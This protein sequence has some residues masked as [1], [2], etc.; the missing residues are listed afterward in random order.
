MLSVILY[1]RNDSYGYN[2][3]K[4]A[5][6]SLNCIAEMLSGEHDEI[7]FVDYNTP[8]DVPTFIE[9]IYDTL[10]PR[11][12]R[13]LR[14]LRVRPDIHNR[15]Y[16]TRTH[17]A[18]LEPICRNIGARRSN[19]QNRWILSTN[20]DM[21]FVPRN[22]EYDL[23]IAVSDLADG[24]Y[25]VPR[26][27]LPEPFW[28][29][30]PRTDPVAIIRTCD[31]LGA[32]LHL[33]E[34]TLAHPYMRFDN[35]GDAQ[36]LP[37][38]TLFDIF[39]F[40][41]R[42][43]HGW[44]VDSNM[45]KRLFHLY[46]AT[47]SLADRLKGYHCDHT[48][49][50]TLAHR[51][52]FQIESDPREFVYNIENPYAQHQSHSWGLP[53]DAIEEIDFG[54]GPP[55]R[56]VSVIQRT[57]GVPQDHDYHSD[58]NDG[59]NYLFY[60]PEHVLPY[61]AAN[62]TV[63]PRDVRLL[64]IGNNP[65]LLTLLATCFRDL[66]F[67][68]PLGWVPDLMCS[69]PPKLADGVAAA[70]EC[71]PDDPSFS[72]TLITNHDV[73][74]FDFGLDAA[75]LPSSD[76][77]RIT[78]WP[79]DQR[80][81]LGAI[82][83]CLA[84]C[85]EECHP[86]SRSRPAASLPDFLVVN[87]N[88][89]P[90]DQFVSQFLLTTKTPYNTR[91][92]KGRARVGDERLYRSH[93]W[94]LTEE[95]MQSFFGY[96]VQ[97]GSAP[98]IA[99]GDCIDFTSLAS[100]SPYKDGDWGVADHTGTW[101]DGRRA[102]VLLSI[103]PAV[104]AD[105]IA[106]VYV[107]ETF[108]GPEEVPISVNAWFEGQH[109]AKWLSASRY[110]CYTSRLILPQGLFSGKPLTRLVF[111]IENP[112]SC[113]AVARHRG[114]EMIGEDPR[115]LS[116][117]IQSLSL[118]SI[119][120]AH[121]HLGSPV[122]FTADGHGAFYMDSCWATPDNYGAWTLGPEASLIMYLGEVP[123]DKLVSAVFTIS[124]AMVSEQFPSLEVDVLFNDENVGKWVLG[125][126]RETHERKVKVEPE[127]LKRRHPL[128]ISFHIPIRRSPRQLN[129]S[130]DTRPLGF[131]LSGLRIEPLVTPI[132]RMGQI[133][134]FTE[135]G[136]AT[137]YLEA[138]WSARDEYGCW[139]QGT[140]ATLTLRL[141]P[142]PDGPTSLSVL[143]SDSMVDATAPALPVEV[144]ANGKML[145]EWTMG[146]DRTAHQRTVELPPEVFPPDGSLSLVFRIATPRTPASMGW[147][148]DPRP[149]G[150][151]LTRAVI[152][153]RGLLELLARGWATLLGRATETP[154]LQP[155][156]KDVSLTK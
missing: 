87:P 58:S 73:L 77:V 61:V 10:T 153:G 102:V 17:L 70:I 97:D 86:V 15:L 27:E 146:L 33:N 149:L 85:A 109:I 19:P 67:S 103:D 40:D 37:R 95:A 116:I 84:S 128:S 115:E 45:C 31:Q 154:Q 152:G 54:N 135:N 143:V 28:E 9:A 110:A 140:E 12:R 106:H 133:I 53:E 125:P 139:T 122:D 132:Y 107:T 22:R 21:I 29:S 137:P 127:V 51:L 13:V 155:E 142:C 88:H 94:K 35:P 52:D 138:G 131:R 129:W 3:H 1:G 144:M 83:R 93:R 75:S 60:H 124:D 65:R 136:N 112:Q 150:I 59:R 123:L 92:R 72:R 80:Y 82:A 38:Q 34:V 76:V 50:R 91:V 98:P 141:D 2:L 119:E 156:D 108:L 24:H 147:S 145:A 48:R 56:F 44:H 47:G 14:V 64:Y 113:A 39:G 23:T 78:D 104:E 114:E 7:I 66:G 99:P 18:A 36:F 46:G 121:Y 62:L 96:D 118:H 101:I 69:P 126:T 20:T 6:I 63:Y 57:L 30:F 68:R 148:S 105:L 81:R 43:M 32:A 90:F 130:G 41:E 100:S 55:A 42:L 5:A 151:R 134:D 79:R 117:K 25:V 4:R 120:N 26:F 49:E 71:G 11:A 111:E 16:G 74:I 89:H 8:N